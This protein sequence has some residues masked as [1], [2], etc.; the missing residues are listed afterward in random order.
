MGKITSF[1]KY[2]IILQPLIM[3][4]GLL[5]SIVA[6]RYG[7]N[8][9]YAEIVIFYTSY[10]LLIF[11]FSL[12]SSPTIIRFLKNDICTNTK[13]NTLVF[14][15]LLQ[16]LFGGIIFSI[17]YTISSSYGNS[18]VAKF[19]PETIDLMII[20]IPVAVLGAVGRSYLNS[21]LENKIYLSCELIKGLLSNIFIV[22]GS[23][24]RLE[25]SEI[26]FG[27]FIIYLVCELPIIFSIRKIVLLQ[28]PTFE[29]LNRIEIISF[30]VSISFVRVTKICFELPFVVFV[31]NATGN[32]AQVSFVSICYRIVSILQK[33]IQLPIDRL[34]PTLMSQRSTKYDLFRVLSKSYKYYFYSLPLLYLVFLISSGYLFKDV[35][36]LEGDLHFFYII[37][38]IATINLLLS[39]SNVLVQMNFKSR[40]IMAL[41]IVSLSLISLSF[42]Y[43][44]SIYGFIIQLFLIR[45]VVNFIST[46]MCYK[47]LQSLISKS[48]FL[49]LCF[50]LTIF[51]SYI[52]YRF[53][54]TISTVVIIVI[55]LLFLVKF[56]GLDCEEKKFLKKVIKL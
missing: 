56:N 46:I 50:S 6:L 39:P 5:G 2:N 44:N 36:L 17:L 49:C 3:I 12:G 34:L 53:S 8:D 47:F 45:L 25:V 30:F 19:E 31:M 14:I 4:V 42:Y 51:F 35:Y 40:Y 24:L 23:L 37:L 11:I 10:S 27:I 1:L 41:S 28:I 55:F 20:L 13:Y 43:F 9:Y 32:H 16:L 54:N 48:L 15:I 26:I 38:V 18:W 33:V 52:T 21:T 7:G 22:I 29:F